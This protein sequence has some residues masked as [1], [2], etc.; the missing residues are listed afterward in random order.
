MPQVESLFKLAT[1]SEKK[2]K[3]EWLIRV[4]EFPLNYSLLPCGQVNFKIKHGMR[5]VT[6]PSLI[7]WTSKQY[8]YPI[9]SELNEYKQSHIAKFSNWDKQDRAGQWIERD[10]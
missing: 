9:L 8:P 2:R 6:T 4:E 1:Q 7:G 5:A 10:E 3:K